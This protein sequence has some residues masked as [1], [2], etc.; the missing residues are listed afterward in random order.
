MA[1]AV[2][3]I[4]KLVYLCVGVW[5]AAAAV[6]FGV[7]HLPPAQI[8]SV[9]GHFPTWM[10]T[11]ALPFQTLWTAARRGDLRVGDPAPDFDLPT[12]DKSARVQLSMHAGVRPVVL[13]FGSYT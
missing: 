13:V 7:M 1:L 6:M 2:R 8:A 5:L 10:I 12:L 3:L 9:V 11:R 4:V